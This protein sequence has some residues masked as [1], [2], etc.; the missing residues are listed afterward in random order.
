MMPLECKV[1]RSVHQSRA[2]RYQSCSP[3]LSVQL[4]IPKQ[5]DPA[6][7]KRQ[8]ALFPTLKYRNSYYI[9]HAWKKSQSRRI[10]QVTRQLT[11]VHASSTRHASH[12]SHQPATAPHLYCACTNTAATEAGLV[13]SPRRSLTNVDQHSA[14]P[15]SINISIS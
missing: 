14:V 15:R 11:K 7:N 5:S 12:S 2:Q 1:P 3:A 13:L 9:T 6:H 8:K 4:G 10:F